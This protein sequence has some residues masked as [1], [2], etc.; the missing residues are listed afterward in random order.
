[1]SDLLFF[2][3]Q[4][5]VILWPLFAL[6]T[7]I[8]SLQISIPTRQR[9][10]HIGRSLASLGKRLRHNL[11][12]TWAFLMAGWFFT[13]F[14]PSPRIGLIPEPWNTGLLVGGFVLLL[15]SEANELG[16]FER[17]MR[18]RVNLHQAGAIRDLKQMDPYAFEALVTETY[19]ALGYHVQHV[20]HSG[21]H[22]VDVEL[23]T[24]DGQEWVVQCKRYD[25]S[26]GEGMIR[27]LY[28]TMISEKADRAVMVTTAEITPPARTW[29]RGKPIDLVDGQELLKLIQRARDKAE[30]TF[31][32]RLAHFIEGLLAPQVPSALRTPKGNGQSSLEKTQP[33]GIGTNHSTPVPVTAIQYHRGV[34]V[35]PVHR[36][37][38]VP[39]TSRPGENRPLYHCRSYPQCRVVLE[40][41]QQPSAPTPSPESGRGG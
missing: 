5:I 38:M 15:L 4:F 26:V 27:E 35:C 6:A 21:D 18:A 25:N 29:A 7:L 19:R 41:L 31:F 13:L 2:I 12:F 9:K 24:N 8:Y 37:P 34:P 17:R 32:D 33:I 11:L 10:L 23:R 40:G 20:G 28:G 14:D 30:G 3:A 36:M 39:H 16:L 1:M 22:G